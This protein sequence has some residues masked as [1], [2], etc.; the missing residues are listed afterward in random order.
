M[1]LS[2]EDTSIIKGVAI[3]MMLLHHLWGF[4]QYAHGIEIP[5]LLVKIGKSGKMCVAIFMV[6]SGYGLW[7]SSE[8]KSQFNLLLR[9]K[10]LYYRYWKVAIPFS[11]IGICIGYYE[12]HIED[13]L[14]TIVCI[15][16]PYNGT[17][18]YI[19]TYAIILCIFPILHK[20]DK[21]FFLRLSPYI[22]LL[23][24]GIG[25]LIPKDGFLLTNLHYIFHYLCYFLL[26]IV[27]AIFDFNTV[28]KH[29]TWIQ[30]RYVKICLSFIIIIGFWYLRIVTG[31][32]F[33]T[34][35]IVPFFIFLIKHIK[36]LLPPKL[37]VL[38]G[39]KSMDMWLVHAFFTWYYL[40][41]CLYEVTSNMYVLLALLIVYSFVIAYILSYIYSLIDKLIGN[42]Y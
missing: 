42:N 22:C 21:K 7:V 11:L 41:W 9:I 1:N 35:I 33:L 12:F 17:W 28:A 31:F 36:V 5:D 10:K 39:E 15:T 29:I 6:L 24:F 30:H 26:G 37:F 40:S 16:Q 25:E 3:I 19:F 14:G 27:L 34:I 13:V 38:L 2:K 8:T 20:I 32:T 4:P 18:W 23:S